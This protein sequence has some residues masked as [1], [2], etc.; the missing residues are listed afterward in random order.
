ME[1]TLLAAALTGAA[2]VWVTNRLLAR[3]VEVDRPTDALI[4]AA[5]V[6]LAVGRVA[7]MIGTGVNPLLR[8]GDILIVRGGV[9]TVFATLGA[10]ATLA[11]THRHRLPTALDQLA[12]AALAGLAGWHGGCLW[13]GTCLGTVSDVPWAMTSAGTAVTR[14]PVELYAAIGMVVAAV[15]VAGFPTRPWTATG[16]GIAAAGGVRALTEPLRVSISGGPVEWYLAAVA[17]G[18]VI[19]VAGHRLTR[20]RP[21]GPSSMET[22][23][24]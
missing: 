15:L 14:H 22:A 3:R 16:L 18:V 19:A 23:P 11:W 6:G 10:L 21:P 5:A 2:A 13:R 1:L 24:P 8:P 17:V 12:P 4:G 7:A 20:T 9:S